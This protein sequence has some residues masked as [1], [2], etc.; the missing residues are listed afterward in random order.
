MALNKGFATDGKGRRLYFPPIGQPRLVPSREAEAQ[1]NEAVFF[2]WLL[3]VVVIVVLQGL[4]L[5]DVLRSEVRIVASA[6]ACVSILAGPSLLARRWQPV[7]DTRITYGRF[8]VN[9][10]SHYDTAV[11][12]FR[13]VGCVLAVIGLI[14]F[15]IWLAATAA[16]QWRGWDD[17][18][19][20]SGL[21]S[22]AVLAVVLWF[23]T[24]HASRVL[25][26]LRRKRERSIRA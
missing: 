18:K 5:W 24:L 20:V 15:G 6:V 23:V 3:A 21:V 14:A 1:F 8:V 25:M 17:G 26:A 4:A 10:L 9:A 19:N 16:E 13:F 7:N 22:F 2:V 11:L 12:I